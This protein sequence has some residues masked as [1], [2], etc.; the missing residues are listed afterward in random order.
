MLKSHYIEDIFTEFVDAWNN[1]KIPVQQQDSSAAYSFYTVINSGGHLTQNQ[2][3]FII[4][5]LEK[6]KIA[7]KA[8]GIDYIADLANPIWKKEFRV[9]DL[10]K[11][12]HI[13]KD[14]DSVV[15]ICAKFP[16]SLK[17]A[18]DKEITFTSKDYN[19]STWD[20]E[21]KIRKIKLY[22]CN[23]IELYEFAKRNGFEIDDTFMI[24]LGEV[25]EIWQN[26]D[27]ITP[28]CVK[29]FGAT[30][31]LCNASEEVI[32][33]WEEHRTCKQG[34]DLLTAKAMGYPLKET[35]TNLVEKIAA[36]YNNHFWLKR[37]EQFFEL[38]KSVNGT[39]VVILNKGDD[40]CEWVQKFVLEAVNS[41]I[42]KADIRVCFRMDKNEDK[43][44]NQ[45][46]KDNQIGGSVD[47]G[48]LFIFQNKPAKWL[49]TSEIDV[50]IILTNSLYPVPSVTTQTW[51][52][53]HTCVCFVGD[54]KAS[55]FKEKNIVEL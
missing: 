14:E 28:Y 32:R 25:E 24:A 18:F 33:W 30:V 13:E 16:Y 3:N 31:D 53:T 9:L 34:H 49:F 42:D 40:H 51:M 22:N 36:S 45:W 15:W 12:I 7:S 29:H 38:Y 46:V 11:K 5:L 43:G 2:A 47:G 50:K 10:E 26:E 1:Q 21:R 55:H 54:V 41:G 39:S 35:P 44:F 8:A 20:P 23:L 48:K 17:T 52:D 19:N 37:L 4:K 27:K 6:Y